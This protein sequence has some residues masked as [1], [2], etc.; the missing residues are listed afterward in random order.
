MKALKWFL[1]SYWL[2]MLGLLIAGVEP[3]YFIV[4]CSFLISALSNIPNK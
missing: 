3:D 2:L 4:G 1:F